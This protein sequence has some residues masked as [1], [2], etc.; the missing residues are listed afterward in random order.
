MPVYDVF[1][2][3]G[4][5]NVAG[6][7]VDNRQYPVGD[8][9]LHIIEQAVETVVVG[10]EGDRDRIIALSAVSSKQGSEFG[11]ESGDGIGNAGLNFLECGRIRM[12]IDLRRIVDSCGAG[13]RR[14]RERVDVG[15]TGTVGKGMQHVVFPIGTPYGLEDEGSLHAGDI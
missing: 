14:I 11:Q 10:L 3:A 12:I 15:G 4:I 13:Y 9:N 6:F 8:G 2:V 1:N 7:F 5:D